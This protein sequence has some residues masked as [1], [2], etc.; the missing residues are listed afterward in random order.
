MGWQKTLEAEIHE[1]HEIPAMRSVF[2]LIPAGY[3]AATVGYKVLHF[4]SRISPDDGKQKAVR[5]MH[6]QSYRFLSGCARSTRQG[7]TLHVL[8]SYHLG[9]RKCLLVLPAV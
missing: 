3:V 7:G 2:P 8:L 5:R 6:L 4:H 9:Y 1:N